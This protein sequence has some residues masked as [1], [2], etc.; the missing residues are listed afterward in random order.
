[1][2][3]P[4]RVRRRSHLLAFLACAV[5]AISLPPFLNLFWTGLL[6]QVDLQTVDWRFRIR[7]P[8][9][10]AQN[11]SQAKSG[12][13]V[14]ID[15]D[16]RAA[17]EN[18]LG[19][20]P[21]NRN[22]HA[23]VIKWLSDAGARTVVMDLLFEY[24]S[25]D[26]AHDRAFI[27]ASRRAGNVIY[28][29]TFHPTQEHQSSEG[30]RLAAKGHL[31]QAEVRGMG[32]IPGARELVLPIPGLMEGAE[33]LGHIMRTTDSDGVLRRIP[34]F[35]SVK[36]GFVPALSIAAAFRHMDVDPA[37]VQIVRGH[38]IRFKPRGA[39]EVVVPIDSHGRAWIN[40]AGPWGKR[41]DHFPY[42]WLL[43]Q[44][45]SGAG[46]NHFPGWFKGK[47]VV[48][49]NLTTGSGD[50][51]TTP[52]ERDF[53]FSEVHLHLLNMLLTRQFLRD[54]KPAEM[55]L[56]LVIPTVLLTVAAL[57]GGPGLIVPTFAA[58]LAAYLITVQQ[59]FNYSGI[60]F[61]VVN[62]ALALTF[63][64]ILL[65]ATR[66]FIVDRERMRFLSALRACLP[67]QTVRE[68]RQSPG[69]I[70]QLLEGHRKELSILF[71]D[72]RGFS[73]FCQKADP[74]DVQRILSEYLTSMTEVIRNHGGTLDKYMGDG[75]MAF[76][77]DG[78]HEGDEKE[79]ARIE[80]Q[81]ANSVRA[82]IAMQKKMTELNTR[83]EG[84][85]RETHLIR[86]GI[87]TGIV[88]VGKMG[89]EHLWDYT[90][91]GTEVNK[92]QRLE[93]AA[94]PGGLLLARRT[95]ALAR[96]Q[97]L[98]SDDLSAK[99]VTLK[100][101]G[102]HTDLYSIPPEMIAQISITSPPATGKGRGSKLKEK[103]TGLVQKSSNS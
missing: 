7:P 13:L 85:G 38:S 92:A 62:P 103:L 44:V 24:P 67:P 57:A 98:L 101:L 15:Y 91:L 56:A 33:G 27:D 76:F 80:H 19:R 30:S 5:I 22:V 10:V 60:I 84:Q 65:L 99:T 3:F 49:A 31:L 53:P 88:T 79:E 52:Y 14:V 71:A 43:S 73:A 86:I 46:K 58:V 55:A 34:L 11:H 63:G 26:P 70:P 102:E 59:A 6:E 17:R 1:M 37:S 9:P 82:G 75:I 16:D 69:R 25:R 78:D 95:Y 83:W 50:Q 47:T 93:S 51:G 77:G 74:L 12:S 2:L 18:G 29:F 39:D 87:N 8:L 40:Y 41:F 20:W 81:A 64:L 35:Y 54:A 100:G 66:F 32:E 23:Q 48:V 90:V 72:I 97:S 42:S 4:H 89:T 28:P 96:N 94:E 68:I 61:P 36:R 21:W 45:K